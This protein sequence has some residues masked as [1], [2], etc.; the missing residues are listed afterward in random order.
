MPRTSRMII[1]GEPAVYHVISRTA[2][3]G[4]PIGADEKD[5]LLEL[6]KRFCRLYLTKVLGFCI[7]SNHFH[8]VVEMQ[9]GDDFSEN[10]L[11]KRLKRHYGDRREFSN[12]ELS[13]YRQKLADLAELMSDIKGNF[14]RYFNR[15][16]HRRGY[17]WGDRF[18]SVIVEKGE[19]LM[20]CLTYIDLNPVRAGLVQKPEKY[21]WDSI[22]Y[23]LQGNLDGFLSTDFGLPEWN[24]LEENE[25]IRRYQAYVYEAGAIG[26]PDQMMAKP[27]NE[28]SAAGE[29]NKQRRGITKTD[30]FRN[31]TRYFT[32]SAVLGSREFVAAHFERFGHLF[33]NRKNRKPV[34]VKGLK[35][36]YSLRRLS[37]L[38]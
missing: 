28:S 7:M 38:G 31:R 19:T 25:R 17:F 34:P 10:D 35:G 27:E 1:E 21:Q 11:R 23:H 2:L 33:P 13:I 16:H 5:F 9:P 15:R 14:G 22:A 20:N 3:D 6:L 4:F 29:E 32:D 12:R 24:A 30:R 36:M 37:E 18:K 8:L 26:Q